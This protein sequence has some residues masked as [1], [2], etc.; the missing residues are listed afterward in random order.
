MVSLLPGAGQQLGAV[1]CSGDAD[2][3]MGAARRGLRDSKHLMGTH[4]EPSQLLPVS[5]Q[6]LSGHI[7]VQKTA[8]RAQGLQHCLHLNSC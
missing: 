2:A 8:P 7:L 3:A 1:L 6:V 4:R 5:T